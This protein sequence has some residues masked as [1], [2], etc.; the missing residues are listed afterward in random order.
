MNK[1]ESKNVIRLSG[2]DLK[3][4]SR[5]IFGW[6][7]SVFAITF[8]YMI[9][10]SSMQEMALAEWDNMPVEVLEF[11]GIKSF[12]IMNDYNGYFGMMYNLLLIAISIFTVTFSAGIVFK[13][14]KS[15]TIEFLYSLHI[16][17][18]EIYVSKILTAV[19]AF[20]LVLLSLV[21]SATIC[22]FLNGGETFILPEFFQ[23]VVISGFIAF[24]FTGIALF[25][26]GVTSR[27][28]VGMVSAMVVVASYMLGY[29]GELLKDK[30]EWLI[31]F[32]PFQLFSP[33]NA[34]ELSNGTITNLVIY[35]LVMIAL[36]TV[37]GIV[38]RKRDFNI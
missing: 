26:A 1:F 2:F 27:I 17:R 8:L 6:M 24:F 15:K 11:M 28:S 12:G 9:L 36:V 32:S 22:G 19:V 14:E 18:T 30:G 21:A 3:N 16:S 38:Y 10:F 13:E 4:N 25:L 7:I 37:G 35:I 29:L 31:Y 20:L 33:T 5:L 23:I 34:L